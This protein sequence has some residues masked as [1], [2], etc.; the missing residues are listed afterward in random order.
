M[1]ESRLRLRL[2]F[3]V[4]FFF[5]FTHLWDLRLLFMH[6]AWTVTAKFDFSYLFQP[7]NAHRALFMN[8]QISLFSNFFIKNESHG[9]IHTFKNYFATVFFNF[10]FSTVSKRTLICEYIF[11]SLSPLSFPILLLSKTLPL[12]L[13]LSY[14]SSFIESTSSPPLHC[15]WQGVMSISRG[16]IS[17]SHE[18]WSNNALEVVFSHIGGSRGRAKGGQGGTTAPRSVQ[19]IPLIVIAN[20]Y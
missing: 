3:S 12:K 10:Q 9:T 8:P 15:Q 7:I 18:S 6:C 11:L 4:F 20:T 16:F 5:C 2:R 19:K 14:L 17:V 13:L 1:W